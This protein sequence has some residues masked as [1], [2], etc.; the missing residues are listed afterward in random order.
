M[1]LAQLIVDY[2]HQHNLSQRQMGAQC[3][4]STGYISLI[5]KEINPQTG[6]PMVPTLGVLNK[7]ALG[8][9]MTL[10]ELISGCDD[11]HVELSDK[12]LPGALD[13]DSL[14]YAL[15]GDPS[16]MTTDDLDDVRNYARYIEERKRKEK[17]KE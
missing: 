14:M 1:T 9:S 7:L 17:K 10:D 3:G 6:K 12:P 16:K 8:M 4:L 15:F 5:E 2:R 11:I 13:D